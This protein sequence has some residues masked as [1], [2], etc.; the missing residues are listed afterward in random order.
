MKKVCFSVAMS[1]YQKDNPDQLDVALNS[2]CTQS[3]LPSEVYL[4]IDG[5]I[6]SDLSSV[7]DK[8][9]SSYDFF[10]IK[11]LEKNGGLGNALRIAVENCKYDLIARMDSDDISAPGRF[12]KQVE[13]FI[14]DPVDV[15]GG[16]TLGFFGDLYKG[17]VSAFTPK[18]TNEEIHKQIAIRTPIS[19]VTAFFRRE[20]VL[21]AG[22]Y[23]DLFYH[24]DYYL[25]ARMISLGMTFRNIPEYL[26]Y[27]RCG[28]NASARHGGIKYFQA[29]SF[30]R[31][32]I[33]EK[34]LSSKKDYYTQMLKR[35]IYE[36]LLPPKARVYIDKK[37]KR[38]FLSRVEVDDILARNKETD[39][40]PIVDK[41]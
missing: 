2:I 1:V 26:V 32:F 12:R 29:E 28:E 6:G 7:I 15:Q 18:L 22:N 24:E 38:H 16:W 4:V 19:H 10:T 3:Y 37:Y 5:P 8:Y 35:I 23:K 17:D 14:S 39:Y 11:Q 9:A 30:L 31:S 27:V 21:A 34:G 13:A 40:I 33:L 25:W 41:G 20:A 36:L